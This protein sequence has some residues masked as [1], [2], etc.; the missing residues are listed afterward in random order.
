MNPTPGIL[1]RAGDAASE[2][3]LGRSQHPH[4]P[5]L[6]DDRR[7]VSREVDRSGLSLL[8]AARPARHALGLHRRGA[9]KPDQSADSERG[10]FVDP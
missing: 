10:A 2:I 7:P 9:R 5:V 1:D 3:A 8:E 4:V 6:G